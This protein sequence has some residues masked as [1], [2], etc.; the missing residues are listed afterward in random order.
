MDEPIL[1]QMFMTKYEKTKI[2]GIRALQISQGAPIKIDICGETNP[3]I[4]ALME[5][6]AKKLPLIVRRKMP[7]GTTVDISAND[8]YCL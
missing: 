1:E 8:L 3:R 4:I 5:L 7:D 6:R 2:L